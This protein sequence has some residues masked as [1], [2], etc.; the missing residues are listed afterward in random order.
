MSQINKLIFLDTETTGIDPEK[1]EI[2]QVAAV[3]VDLDTRKIESAINYYIE[4]TGELDAAA[5]VVNGYYVGKWTEEERHPLKPEIV[6]PMLKQFLSI[7]NSAIVAH[8][9]SF[10]RA[11]C[12]SLLSKHGISRR[13]QPKYWFDTATMAFLFML[14]SGWNRVSL[15]YAK[16]QLKVEYVRKKQHDALD[17]CYLL[18]D[19][20]FKMIDL[21]DIRK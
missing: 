18:V 6:A 17:D 16:E 10:D 13:D 5:S 14:K 4:A 12:A 21:I 3:L 7:R 15:D 9:S 20:F 11:F 8:N 19:T 1:N 2:I